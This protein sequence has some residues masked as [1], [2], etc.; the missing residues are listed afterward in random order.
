M[1]GNP[2]DPKPSLFPPPPSFGAAT[3][4][5]NSA[6][7]LFGSA[8]PTANR[9]FGTASS[10][11]N[12]PSSGGLFGGLRPTPAQNPE[13]VS[14]NTASQPAQA[15]GSSLF[16]SAQPNIH[17]DHNASF[18]APGSDMGDPTSAF[19]APLVQ[20]LLSPKP[21][22]TFEEGA[23]EES[24][25]STTYDLPG[26]KT[27]MPSNSVLKH[28]IAKIEFKNIG[29]EHV[30]VPKLRTVAFLKAKLRNTSKIPLLAGPVGLNLDGSFLG[31][32]TF[33]R[34]SIGE[35]LSLNLGVDPAIK[36][37]YNKPEV[38]VSE[39]ERLRVEVLVPRG[40]KPDGDRIATGLNL[41]DE[42]LQGGR[43]RERDRD[44]ERSSSGGEIVRRSK[45][46]DA[47][48][49]ADAEL[50]KTGEVLWHVRLAPGAGVKLVLQYEAGFPS[51]ETVVNA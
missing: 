24:G 5:Q 29:F 31:Q 47:W 3:S 17:P 10:S 44:R 6:S 32:A 16:G 14:E 39:E 12:P 26:L 13:P 4:S 21:T 42:M 8:H 36:V 30:V 49:T 15:Q 23:W 46:I 25:M 28:K 20:R 9:L 37:V 50:K 40:L 38:P 35:G 2:P 33:P 1:F 41:D 22:L 18:S 48:G 27:L 34:C 11:Q 45:K 51:G 43:E 7:A 19:E